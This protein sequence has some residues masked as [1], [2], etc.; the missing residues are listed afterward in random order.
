MAEIIE[1]VVFRAEISLNKKS[2]HPP[3]ATALGELW[4]PQQSASIST[5]LGEPWP[6]QQSASIST[7]LGEP[8]PPKQSASIST[9][10][11]EL[12]PPQQSASISL[13]L[14][15]SHFTALSLLSSDL[16]PH[17]PSISNE[18]FLFFFL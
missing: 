15:S 6:P 9:A 4:P 5:A 8:W 18:V 1:A 11:G 17:H 14:A 13:Y 12:W 16:L 3:G 2:I 7:A 10:L